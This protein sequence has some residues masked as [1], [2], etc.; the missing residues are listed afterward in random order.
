MT[1]QFA[2]LGI[3]AGAFLTVAA[4]LLLVFIPYGSG[5]FV[6]TTLTAGLGVFLGTISALVIHIERK[7]Q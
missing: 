5:E 2:R 3:Y 4:L 6:I 7:R 1:G